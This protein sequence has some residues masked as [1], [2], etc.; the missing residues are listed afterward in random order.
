[1][2]GP[3]LEPE[4]ALRIVERVDRESGTGMAGIVDAVIAGIEDAGALKLRKERA[5]HA[6]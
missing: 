6:E 1:M 5:R 4:L 3:E 2:A